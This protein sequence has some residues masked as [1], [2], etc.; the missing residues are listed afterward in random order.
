MS[1][2]NLA[3]STLPPS[4]P[5][6]QAAKERAFAKIGTLEDVVHALVGRIDPIL[7]PSVPEPAGDSREDHVAAS[8]VAM[9]FE[10]LADRASELAA[11]VNRTHDRVEI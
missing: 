7:T 9:S 6:A 3:T 11:Y 1:D 8:D 5:P 4:P 2:F 10:R